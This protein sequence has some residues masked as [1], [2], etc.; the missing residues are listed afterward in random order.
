MDLGTASALGSRRV[1]H[2]RCR[3]AYGKRRDFTRAAALPPR[4]DGSN[5]SREE[6]KRSDLGKTLP[7]LPFW[8]SGRT[9]PTGRTRQR[10]SG[11]AA[12]AVGTALRV[13]T[14]ADGSP[15]STG[16]TLLG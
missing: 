8:A 3:A 13:R 4:A 1:A 9:G 5:L 2:A 10:A 16:S 7:A 14:S 15:G 6:I 11:S 12:S